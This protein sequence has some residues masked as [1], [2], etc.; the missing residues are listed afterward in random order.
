VNTEVWNIE[1]SDSNYTKVKNLIEAIFSGQVDG[2]QLRPPM[3]M[4]DVQAALGISRVTIN[5]WRTDNVIPQTAC[6]KVIALE[7]LKVSTT[8]ML[9]YFKDRATLRD[10]FTGNSRNSSQDIY[11]SWQS[12]DAGA[13]DYALALILSARAEQ[14]N[15]A[16][17][18]GHRTSPSNYGR[19]TP[20]CPVLSTSGTKKKKGR[21]ASIE[22]DSLTD[23]EGQKLAALMQASRQK[24]GNHLDFDEIATHQG[25][26]GFSVLVIDAAAEGRIKAFGYRLLDDDWAAIAAICFKPTGWS[27]NHP[28]GLTSNTFKNQVSEVKQAIKALNGSGSHRG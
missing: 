10:L 21:M 25:V 27:D 9:D 28:I 5:H 13:Q 24:W 8:L 18:Q 4:K 16:V 26:T 1:A 23:S 20:N 19:N 7:L 22:G 14:G 17:L 11:R 12:L 2:E 3:A 15:V 6:L